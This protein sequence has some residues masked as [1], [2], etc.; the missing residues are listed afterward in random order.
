MSSKLWTGLFLI[1][2][3]AWIWLSNM[4]YL[5]FKRDW[6]LII[7]IVGLYYLVSGL[8]RRKKRRDIRKLLDDLEKGK[9]KTEDVINKLEE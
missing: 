2:I 3:G 8:S 4:G 9:I 7:I 5:N 6:P 1:V